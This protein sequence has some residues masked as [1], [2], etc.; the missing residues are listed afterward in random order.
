MSKYTI[1]L[2]YIRD[3]MLKFDYIYIRFIWTGVYIL[4]SVLVIAVT[5]AMKIFIKQ[6]T[7][8]HFTQS[9]PFDILYALFTSKQ[10]SFCHSTGLIPYYGWRA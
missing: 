6:Q 5:I 4:I 10:K 9:A 3:Y 2:R 8:T 1:E 7:T